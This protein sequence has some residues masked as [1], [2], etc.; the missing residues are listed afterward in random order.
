[1][2]VRRTVSSGNCLSGNYPLGGGGG[3]VG[4]MP[5]GEKTVGEMSVESLSGYTQRPVQNL[6]K[7]CN[8][9]KS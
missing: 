2:S 1:M 8:E 4:E 7:H 9:V 5:V 6:D 3:S